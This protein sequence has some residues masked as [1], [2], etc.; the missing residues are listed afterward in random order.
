M[1]VQNKRT[2]NTPKLS[3][4]DI[5]HVPKVSLNLLFVGQLRE[6]GIDVYFL[7]HGYFMQDPQKGKIL[8]IGHRVGWLFELKSLHVPFKTVIATV[9]SSIWHARLGHL[10][11][12]KLGSLIFNSCLDPVK[13]EHFDCVSCQL[14][15]YHALPF[16]NSNSIFS[17]P[18][19]LIH[20]DIWGPALHVTVDGSRYFVIFVDD[21]SRFT[22]IYLMQ[23]ICKI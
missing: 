17:T 14:S 6:P 10:L 7:S 9:T 11:G 2:I 20:F 22:W 21:S 15:K 19:D 4:F 18:F 3:I 1:H 23:N 13:P 12:S 8:G 16:S 5:F